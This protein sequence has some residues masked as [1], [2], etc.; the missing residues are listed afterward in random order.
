LYWK[1]VKDQLEAYNTKVSSIALRKNILDY[2]NRNNYL[3]EMANIRGVLGSKR[4]PFQTVT[5]LKDR[6]TELKKLVGKEA[7]LR[8]S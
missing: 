8:I 4:L 6:H 1:R 7:F 5:R 2:Q 3:N